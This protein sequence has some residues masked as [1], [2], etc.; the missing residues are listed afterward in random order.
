MKAI[1]FDMDGVIV[2]SEYVHI[3][4]EEAVFNKYDIEIDDSDWK[5]FKGKTPNDIF[6]YVIKRYDLK[7]VS[8]KEMADSKVNFY[9]D[10]AKTNLR[11]FDGFFELI[12][13]LKKDYLIALTTSSPKQIQEL[14]FKQFHLNGLFDVV[15]TGDMIK[16]G[17]PDPEPYILTIE[18]LKLKPQECIVIEDSVNGIRS[19]KL[20]GVKTIAV[21]YT[22]NK[23]DLSEADYIVT[24]LIEVKTLIKNDLSF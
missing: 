17:K 21:T 15:V 5:S 11:L 9:L 20:A 4:A 6:S 3:K 23:E 24:D 7:N 18:K 22:F 8:V 14:A 19:A 16:N 10:I 13:F 2:D 12:E 1:I